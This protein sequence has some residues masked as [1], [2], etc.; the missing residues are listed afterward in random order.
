MDA[1]R[2]QIKETRKLGLDDVIKAIRVINSPIET[3][4]NEFTQFEYKEL[5][6]DMIALDNRFLWD[7]SGENELSQQI[8]EISS[9]LFRRKPFELMDKLT[10]Q[11]CKHAEFD[12]DSQPFDLRLLTP[13]DAVT[14]LRVKLIIEQFL[15][16]RELRLLYATVEYVK[17]KIPRERG[18]LVCELKTYLLLT[19]SEKKS[20]QRLQ[21]FLERQGFTHKPFQYRI[22]NIFY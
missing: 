3:P 7:Q 10:K 8:R 16:T 11:I 1:A 9:E 21:I 19:Q 20:R 4:K 18:P 12:T 17:E 13:S 2:S 14:T 22:N 15:L 6:E 5:F